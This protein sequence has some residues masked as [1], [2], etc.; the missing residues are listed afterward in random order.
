MLPKAGPAGL[1]IGFLAYTPIILAVN[2]CFGEPI[3]FEPFLLCSAEL[4]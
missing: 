2:Q 1:L 3:S 4:S